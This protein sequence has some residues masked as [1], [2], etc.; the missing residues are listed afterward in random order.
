ME[1]LKIEV[2]HKDWPEV[3][4]ITMCGT[5]SAWSVYRF[6][7][8]TMLYGEEGLEYIA[9]RNVAGEIISKCSFTEEG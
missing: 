4:S 5:D 7:L 9:L 1:R 6:L 8:S 2:K 3:E